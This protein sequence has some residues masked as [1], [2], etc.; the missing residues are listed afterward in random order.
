MQE[1]T[2]YDLSHLY[3]CDITHLYE[4]TSTCVLRTH[5]FRYL[6]SVWS[7]L[8]PLRFDCW[9]RQVQFVGYICIWFCLAASVRVYHLHLICPISSVHL[10][11]RYY[12][13][14]V[15]VS[16]CIHD[17]SVHLHQVSTIQRIVFY[18]GSGYQ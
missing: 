3:G 1:H 10:Y 13:V 12:S 5:L 2:T 6:R 8:A 16:I 17:W 18:Y 9:L 4:R 7:I 11:C 15:S 14:V